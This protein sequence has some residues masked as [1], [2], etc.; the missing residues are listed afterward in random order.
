MRQVEHVRIV[1]CY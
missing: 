1:T